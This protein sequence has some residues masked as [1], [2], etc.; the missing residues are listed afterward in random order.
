MSDGAQR[1][2]HPNSIRGW[3]YHYA[4]STSISGPSPLFLGTAENTP[5]EMSIQIKGKKQDRYGI[6]GSIPTV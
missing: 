1:E 4:Y 2:V 6:G 3:D 5:G